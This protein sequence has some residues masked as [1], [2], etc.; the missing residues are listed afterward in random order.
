MK[1][2]EKRITPTN[3]DVEKDLRENDPFY[4]EA[5]KNIQRLNVSEEEK[6][7]R[8]D[9]LKRLHEVEDHNLECRSV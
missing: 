1:A 4:Q 7:K 6:R 9:L 8:L 2:Y 3:E 5:I